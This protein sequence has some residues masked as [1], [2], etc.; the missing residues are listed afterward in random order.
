M[1]TKSKPAGSG[2]HPDESAPALRPS[3]AGRTTRLRSLKTTTW[4]LSAVGQRPVATQPCPDPPDPSSEYANLLQGIYDAVL[5]TTHAGDIVESNTRAEEF[6]RWSREALCG[7]NVR[8]LLVGADDRLLPA[9]HRNLEDHRYTLIEGQCVRADRRT[10]PAEIAVSR[11]LRRGQPHLC[12]FVRNITERKRAQDALKNAISR[13]E[14]HDRARAHFVSNVSHELKTPLTSMSYAIYNMLN[15][16]VGPLPAKVRRYLQMLDG[17]CRRMLA[18]VSDILD[19]RR[20]DTGAMKLDCH[21]IPLSRLIHCS[22]ASL[23]LTARQKGVTLT[24]QAGPVNVFID[25]DPPKIER[26]IMN[27]V[28]NAIKFTPAGGSITLTLTRQAQA[29][30]RPVVLQVDDTGIGI[31]PEALPRVTERYFTVGDQPTGTGLGLAI[32]K[33]IVQAH[34]GSLRVDSPR[35][36]ARDGT[37]ITVAM[38]ASDAPLVMVIDDDPLVRPTIAGQVESWGFRVREYDEGTAALERIKRERPDLLILD[39]QLPGI[40]GTD[41]ILKLK[42]NLDMM[43]MPVVVLTGLPL[44][45]KQSRVLKNFGIPSLQKPWREDVLREHVEMAFLAPV[46]GIRRP[47]ARVGKAAGT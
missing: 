5:V 20:I 7:R 4:K 15:G 13:L 35:P 17:D 40:G 37:R 36:G 26:V 44:N 8:D 34:G 6:F 42:A 22:L 24:V 21:R 38:P 10:F 1:K 46:G 28:G 2:D 27:I 25:C 12:V 29:A 18:T 19:L 41:V 30:D 16:V 23:H 11:L 31:P 3:G 32:S 39:L 47:H 9:I 33:E 43:R 14:E 45:E